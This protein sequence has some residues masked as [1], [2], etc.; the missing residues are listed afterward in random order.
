MLNSFFFSF[1][2][3]IFFIYISNFILF[4]HDPSE[5]LLIPSPLP[6]LTDPPSHASLSWRSPT[7]RHRAFIRPRASPFIAVPQGHPLLCM[8]LKPLSPSLV[9]L[10]GWWFSPWALWWYWLVHIVVPP[11]G[12]QTTSSPLGP[13]SSSSIEDPVLSPMDGCEHQLLYLSGTAEPLR[14]L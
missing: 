13:F 3:D 1:L 7:L 12:L 6:L 4:P 5:T 11:M 9:V 2:L 14:L 8:W 10:F